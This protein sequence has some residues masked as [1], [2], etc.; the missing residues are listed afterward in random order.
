MPQ[1]TSTRGLTTPQPPH[2]IHPSDEHVRQGLAGSPTDAPRQT[3]HSTSNSAE[4]SVKGKYD[5]R[6]RVRRPSPNSVEASRDE[7]VRGGVHRQW[8]GVPGPMALPVPRQG[9]VAPLLDE[10]TCVALGFEFCL[11]LFEGGVDRRS[12][13]A[14][15]TTGLLTCVARESR[16]GS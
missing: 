10:R 12:Q 4:G 8:R 16:N 11:P 5:G 2:S 7:Q 9:D 14:D 6:Q 15:A 1:A 3:K 13:R